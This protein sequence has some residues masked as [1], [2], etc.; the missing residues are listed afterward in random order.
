MELDS[1]EEDDPPIEALIGFDDACRGYCSESS[2]YRDSE[3]DYNFPDASEDDDT[4]KNNFFSRHDVE[5]IFRIPP[6]T[7]CKT[8]KLVHI[9]D[10]TKKKEAAAIHQQTDKKDKEACRRRGLISAIEDWRA[11]YQVG[12]DTKKEC[13][14][15]AKTIANRHQCSYSTLKE[16]LIPPPPP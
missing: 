14:D 4:A 6:K 13:K 5:R 9:L 15:S 10:E 12:D 16:Y 2:V 11:Q 1:S 3:D 8:T 7:Y